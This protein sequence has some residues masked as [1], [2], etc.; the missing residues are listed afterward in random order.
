MY[1]GPRRETVAVT[2]IVQWSMFQAI[3]DRDL[4]V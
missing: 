4:V 3:T 2:E 1:S